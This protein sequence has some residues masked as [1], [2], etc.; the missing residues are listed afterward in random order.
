MTRTINIFKRHS[1]GH[2]DIKKIEVSIDRR[3]QYCDIWGNGTIQIEKNLDAG[4]TSIYVHTEDGSKKFKMANS[5]SWFDQIIAFIPYEEDIDNG[6]KIVHLAPN[7]NIFI[8][9][10]KKA[11]EIVFNCD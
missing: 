4:S 5:I 8:T 2:P 9:I 11:T 3:R 10:S 1:E 6:Y 7:N